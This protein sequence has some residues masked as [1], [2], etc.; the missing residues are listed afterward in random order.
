MP[1]DNRL[2][3]SRPVLAQ[4]SSEQRPGRQLRAL[5]AFGVLSWTFGGLS[6]LLGALLFVE[7]QQSTSMI[8][9]LG[10][11]ATVGLL[12]GAVCWVLIRRAASSACTQLTVALDFDAVR[13]IIEEFALERGYA[14]PYLSQRTPRLQSRQSISIIK[15]RPSTGPR[16]WPLEVRVSAADDH[17]TVRI[18]AGWRVRTTG[19]AYDLVKKIRSFD[20]TMRTT[21][22][23]KDAP[24]GTADGEVEVVFGL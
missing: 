16:S 18:H 1:V 2:A 15:L 21:P 9:A 4:R 14:E 3:H 19:H 13:G 5:G 8:V 17:C 7:Q 12:G 22:Q 20:H 24:P 6:G 11:A 10:F 23:A